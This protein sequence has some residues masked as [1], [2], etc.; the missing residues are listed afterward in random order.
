MSKRAVVALI[1]CVAGLALIVFALQL[2]NEAPS[3]NAAF[4]RDAGAE[5]RQKKPARKWNLALG[6]AVLVAPELGFG[7]RAS[8]ETANEEDKIVARIDGQLQPLRELYR[9][10]SEKNPN[11]MGSMLFQITVGPSGEVILAK[12]VSSRITDA[13]F[14]KAVAVEVSKWWFQDLVS[15]NAI[16]F[17]PLLFVREG[18]EIST[19][20]QWEKSLGNFAEKSTFAKVNLPPPQYPKAALA[21]PE[22]QGPSGA[23]KS[24]ATTVYKIKY[25][26]TIRSEPSFAS[27]AVASFGSGTKVTLLS[28]HG[29][30]LKVRHQENGPAGFIRK[31]LVVPLD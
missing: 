27:S 30:W 10:E 6:D 29:D 14:K 23:L 9:S 22:R 12:E 1:S 26:T 7:I 4:G 15:D 17:C 18:M 13:D 28:R 20:L 25:P 11:L 24:A 8:R 5:S 31:E 3:K 21:T 19:V 16:I 2:K